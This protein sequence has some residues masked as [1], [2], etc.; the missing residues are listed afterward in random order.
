[1]RDGGV[2]MKNILG[3]SQIISTK[4]LTSSTHNFGPG[5]STNRK[6]IRAPVLW[7]FLKKSAKA[8]SGF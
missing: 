7:F 6:I 3:V 4:N 2:A 1:L 8:I 5:C